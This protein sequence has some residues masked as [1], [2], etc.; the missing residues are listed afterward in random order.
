MSLEA[1]WVVIPRIPDATI[2][3]SVLALERGRILGGDHATVWVGRWHVDRDDIDVRVR[4]F[5]HDESAHSILVPDLRDFEL[6]GR[7]RASRDHKTIEGSLAVIGRPEAAVPL[8]LTRVAELPEP[9]PHLTDIVGEF[10]QFKRS[11]VTCEAC[12]WHGLGRECTSG[13]AAEGQQLVAYCCPKCTAR[14]SMVPWPL[15]GET[16]EW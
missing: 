15:I 11:A 10:T 4:V 2:A 9:R 5:V 3:R 13:Q 7:L 8:D 12:G 16:H 6:Q 14:V 1:L